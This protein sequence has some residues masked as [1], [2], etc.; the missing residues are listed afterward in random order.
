MSEATDS[1]ALSIIIPAKNEAKAIGDVVATARAEY[2]D[3]EI[4]V[5]DDGSDDG[6]GPVAEAREVVRASFSV[7]QYTPRDSAPWDDAFERFERLV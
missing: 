7:D 5:V 3:A 4:I 2:P 1:T 6:T